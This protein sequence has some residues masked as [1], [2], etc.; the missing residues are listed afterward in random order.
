VIMSI[1]FEVTGKNERRGNVQ[2]KKVVLCAILCLTL[3]MEEC[4]SFQPFSNRINHTGNQVV[5]TQKEA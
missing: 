3:F 1:F 4:K 5:H 2:V